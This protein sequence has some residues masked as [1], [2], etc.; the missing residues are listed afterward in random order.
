[1]KAGRVGVGAACLLM[2]ACKP[3]NSGGPLLDAKG[4]VVGARPKISQ[5]VRFTRESNIGW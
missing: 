5:S 2:T 3:G 1:M 4:E